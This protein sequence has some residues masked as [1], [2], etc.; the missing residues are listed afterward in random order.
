[1]EGIVVDVVMNYG[2]SANW[3]PEEKVGDASMSSGYASYGNYIDIQVWDGTIIRLAH[4]LPS[5]RV[6][7]GDHVY[8][9]NQIGL[10]GNTGSSTGEHVHIEAIGGGNVLDYFLR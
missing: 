10:V 7:V 6:S 5:N 2:S 8:A 4:Q 3:D 9:G 1:M